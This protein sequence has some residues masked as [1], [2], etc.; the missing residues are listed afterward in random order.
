[1]EHASRAGDGIRRPLGLENDV[2]PGV[3]EMGLHLRG[4]NPVVGRDRGASE[5]D[6]IAPDAHRRLNAGPGPDG[7]VESRGKGRGYPRR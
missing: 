7:Q 6:L 1:M 5:A 3:D 4:I 2:L